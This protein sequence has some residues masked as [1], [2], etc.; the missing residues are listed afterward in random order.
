VVVP[1]PVVV[2]DGTTSGAGVKGSAVPEGVA[3]TV[4]VK[5][6][7]ASMILRPVESSTKPAPPSG[8]VVLVSDAG[9]AADASEGFI[10]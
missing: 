3:G 10:I 9:S 6:G 1:P 4:D 5:S 8:G 2:V 7:I